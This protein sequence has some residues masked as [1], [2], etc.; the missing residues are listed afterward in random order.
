MSNAKERTQEYAI[1]ILSGAVLVALLFAMVF[2]LRWQD[3]RKVPKFCIE[4]ESAWF[5]VADTKEGLEREWGRPAKQF[6]IPR[7]K[8]WLKIN[9]VK[10]MKIEGK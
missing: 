2:Y 3:C 5:T 7:G 8:K 1:W 4:S 6:D 10:I 9:I